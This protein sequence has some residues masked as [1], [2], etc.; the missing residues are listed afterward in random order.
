MVNT[1]HPI[2]GRH[3]V[4]FESSGILQYF[5]GSSE[6]VRPLCICH[7]MWKTPLVLWPLLCTWRGL[8]RK[9]WSISAPFSLWKSFHAAN[10]S[11]TGSRWLDE[12][13]ANLID[14][15]RT[16]ALKLMFAFRNW[17]TLYWQYGLILLWKTYLFGICRWWKYQVFCQNYV[18]GI[19]WG[20]NERGR[21]AEKHPFQL[22]IIF[23]MFHFKHILKSFSLI[24]ILPFFV[25]T[26]KI[27]FLCIQY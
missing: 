23:K 15:T 5:V 12:W 25:P 7:A 14:I 1:E 19:D 27:H 3:K 17:N 16:A 13:S 6:S 8:V 22:N 4:W 20:P 9:S 2:E 21:S 18:K 11:S 10:I 26:W 24:K